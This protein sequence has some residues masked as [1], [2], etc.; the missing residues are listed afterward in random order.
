MENKEEKEGMR[1]LSRL[2]K[3]RVGKDEKTKKRQKRQT[4]KGGEER[5]E[6]IQTPYFCGLAFLCLPADLILQPPF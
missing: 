5:T 2:K 6:H 4:N 3:R 1:Q